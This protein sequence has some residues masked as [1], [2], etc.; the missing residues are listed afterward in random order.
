[1]CN[2]IYQYDYLC[3]RIRVYAKHHYR[4]VDTL[5]VTVDTDYRDVFDISSKTL[6][7]KCGKDRYSKPK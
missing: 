4:D 2:S 3:D 6:E 5:G 1:M 7:Y